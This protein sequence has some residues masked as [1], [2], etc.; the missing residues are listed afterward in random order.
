MKKKRP[1]ASCDGHEVDGVT[2]HDGTHF[3]LVRC[4]LFLTNIISFFGVLLVLFL[5]SF[6]FELFRG[7]GLAGEPAHGTRPAGP[8]GLVV[9]LSLSLG[10]LLARLPLRLGWLCSAASEPVELV[11]PGRSR[12]RG[13]A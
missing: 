2:L 5:L 13:A 6:S 4:F 12:T 8:G 9:G 3:L 11:T 1:P 10:L 7:L